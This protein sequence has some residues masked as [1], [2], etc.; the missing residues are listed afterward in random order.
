MASYLELLDL[1]SDGPLVN[2]AAVA[3]AVA[4]GNVL[5]EPEHDANRC[6][7]AMDVIRSNPDQAR[8][9]LAAFLG[10]NN[11]KTVAAIKATTDTELQA[12][13]D[14]VVPSMIAAATP[15]E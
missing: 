8:S 4:A 3:A 10:A 5:A 9:I 7:W 6:R 11:T 14:G 15:S 1:A 12:F 2:R 13:V